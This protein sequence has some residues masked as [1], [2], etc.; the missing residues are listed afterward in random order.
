MLAP[1]SQYIHRFKNSLIIHTISCYQF[2]TEICKSIFDAGL[3]KHEERAQEV[4]EFWKC[5]N[6][7][8]T[9]NKSDGMNFITTFLEYKKSVSQQ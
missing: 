7:A 6:E 8:K 4:N 5:I 2:F 3:S 9:E 1:P